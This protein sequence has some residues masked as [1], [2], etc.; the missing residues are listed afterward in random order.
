ME[1]FGDSVAFWILCSIVKFIVTPS[2]MILK[3]KSILY[4]IVV[5]LVENI[6]RSTFTML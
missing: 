3:G 1:I 5:K 6:G 4:T 2:L